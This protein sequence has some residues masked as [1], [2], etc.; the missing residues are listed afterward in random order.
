MKPTA[1]NHN[2]SCTVSFDSG[3]LGSLQNR[4]HRTASTKKT[5][6]CVLF[7]PIRLKNPT[8]SPMMH[9][10]MVA[11]PDIDPAQAYK[12]P[13]GAAYTGIKVRGAEPAF[14][15]FCTW[16]IEPSTR[17]LSPRHEAS[18][19]ESATQ[20]WPRPAACARRLSR[21][22]QKQGPVEL[23][24]KALGNDV[25]YFWVQVGHDNFQHDGPV[26]LVFRHVQ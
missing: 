18:D 19:S 12:G 15:T 16:V 21:E 1:E 7:I 26:F 4:T 6:T 22:S 23:F 20:A 3:T 8:Y 9:A 17:I 11:S 10:T 13:A 24:L 14:N 5:R 25:T 2:S